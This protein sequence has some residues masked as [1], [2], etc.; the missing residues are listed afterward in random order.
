M[1]P[2]FTASARRRGSGSTA[3]TFWMPSSRHIWIAISPMAPI[4]C[5]LTESPSLISASCT[6]CSATADS[7]MNSA[8]S[9]RSSVGRTTSG[10]VVAS[11]VADVQDGLL[12][13][14]GAGVHEV[15][16]LDR[17]DVRGDLDDLAHHL[18]AERHRIRR[19]A[20]RLAE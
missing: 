11:D 8:R 19:R 6:A 7:E 17:G 4:P 15:A 20:A 12:L 3:N 13:V 14:R 2:N 9:R 1:A 5:T 16:D 10:Y 18:V